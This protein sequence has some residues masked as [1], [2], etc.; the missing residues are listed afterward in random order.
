MGCILLQF[1]IMILI[2]FNKY[3]D[4]DVGKKKKILLSKVYDIV[5]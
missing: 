4:I 3:V 1:Y 2:I 5:F